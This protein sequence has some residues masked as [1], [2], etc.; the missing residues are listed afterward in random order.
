MPNVPASTAKRP[1]LAT[2]LRA[3]ALAGAVLIVLPLPAF[4]DDEATPDPT[5]TPTPTPTVVIEVAADAT[6]T[7]TPEPTPTPTPTPTAT[8]DPTP[9]PEPTPTATPNPT[10]TAS[11]PPG[12]TITS[13][14]LYRSA[15]AVRQYRN[16]WC[17]PAATQTMMN[18]I[19]RQKIRTYSRQYLLYRQI[20]MNNRYTYATSGN[21]I[22]GWAWALR[23]WTKQPYTA[24][25][26]TSR[27]TAINAMVE[28]MDRTH[29]PVG[30]TI[31]RGTH[32]W[33]VLGYKA[34]V[35]LDDPT[36]RTILGVYVFGPLGPGSSDPYPYRYYNLASFA[37][38]YT[39]YHEWQH[40][41][42]WE[43]R[44]VIVAD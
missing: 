27:T 13:V 32:A 29:H 44:Y 19:L 28:A 26:Y 9:T 4:A 21:D 37:K 31:K 16:T 5:A 18:M 15:A 35:D 2:A 11:P 25:S 23:H 8:P 42:V 3:V 43:G 10:P 39:A 22:A 1:R 40:H 12:T 36:K 20:R 41:V 24:K 38:V 34:R 30:V 17:V 33:V 14:V 6:P 7:P